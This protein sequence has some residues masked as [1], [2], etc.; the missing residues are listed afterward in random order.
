V[1][2]TCITGEEIRAMRKARSLDVKT[3]ERSFREIIA[4]AQGTDWLTSGITLDADIFQNIFSLR[5]A[6]RDLWRSNPYLMKYQEQLAANVFG[7]AGIMNRMKVKETEDRVVHASDEKWALIEHEERINR[8]IEWAESKTGTRIQRYRAYKLAEGLARSHN[9]DILRGTATIKV[10]QPDVFANKV[11]EAAWSEWQRAQ[12]CDVR[13]RR[14]YNTLRQLM[15]WSCA[16][17][18]DNFPRMITGPTVNKFGFALQLINAEWCDYFLNIGKPTDETVIRMGIEYENKPWG[19]GKPTAYYFIKRLPNDWQWN[20]TGGWG[21]GNGR[22][23]TPK[24]HDRIPAEEIIHYMRDMDTEGTRGIPW[25]AGAIGKI[26]HLDNYEIAEVIAARAEACK[27]G[28]LYSDMI[29]EG[30]M[31]PAGPDPIKAVPK[32]RVKPG[33]IYGLPWGVKYQSCDPTHPTADFG[34]F[35]QGMGQAATAAFPG[36]DYNV[37]FNDL[38]NINFSSGRLGRLDTNE[39]NKILQRMHIEKAETTI[40][41]TWLL[42]SLITG[43]VPLPS[44]KFQKFN[45]PLFQGRRWAQVDEIKAVTA[46]ALRVAN[47]F[48]SD[49]RECADLG[50]DSEEILFE[51][52]ESNMMKEQFGIDPQKTVQK[53]PTTIKDDSEEPEGKLPASNGSK[54]N[55][56]D[57]AGRLNL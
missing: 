31:M 53:F 50:T 48:S 21:Y 39:V 16:R 40:F 27:T 22:N 38:A 18:G 5:A 13:G 7:E 28:W 51:V 44:S 11:I 37:I 26:R 45:K 12:Y 43:A 3:E 47:L 56:V 24:T 33:G 20:R 41:E 35:R 42:W 2:H 4:T 15:L 54:K 23:L 9:D 57:L 30:G 1:N 14:S 46:A 25:G 34:N 19:L 36:A 29:P 32:Q 49:Q 8:I 6:M 17:D 55:Q 52:A 10:G